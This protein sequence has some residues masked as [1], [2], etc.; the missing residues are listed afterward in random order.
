MKPIGTGPSEVR[1]LCRIAAGSAAL[2]GLAGCGG[3][4]GAGASVGNVGDEQL[5]PEGGSFF[6][7]PNQ[8]GRSTHLHLAE[9]FWA[10]LVDVFDMDSNGVPSAL[11]IFKD[12]P[13]NEN[14][15]TDADKFLLETNPITQRTR[16]I[17][18]RT[19]GAAP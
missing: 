13:I 5:K 16:L 4:G 1:R 19:H 15:Q 2:A 17:V 6:V 14:V 9:M 18:R 12:F 11:P 8:A 7:D 10:R 3:G